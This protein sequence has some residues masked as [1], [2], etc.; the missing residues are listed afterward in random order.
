MPSPIVQRYA[1]SDLNDDQCYKPRNKKEM[2]A[3]SEELISLDKE[4]GEALHRFVFYKRHSFL[5]AC[6]D[7]N[8]LYKR[9]SN[10]Y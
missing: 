1:P 4:T 7:T 3:I 9:N 2:A 5:F 8:E 10:V 6:A